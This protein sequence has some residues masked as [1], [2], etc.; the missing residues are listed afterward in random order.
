[1]K[2]YDLLGE[3]DVFIG[4]FVDGEYVKYED[5]KELLDTLKEYLN[6]KSSDGKPARMPLREKLKGLI[7]D[8]G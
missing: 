2:R 7:N 4:E 8:L 5:V 1:M 3:Y 6:M